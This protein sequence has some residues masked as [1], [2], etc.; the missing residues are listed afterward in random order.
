MIDT[1]ALRWHL[2]RFTDLSA[3]HLYDLLRL[4]SEVFVV[5]QDC[6]YLDIDGKDRHPEAWHLLGLAP[7][8]SLVAYLRIMPPGLGHGSGDFAEPS[9]GRVVTAPGW[10]G[11]GLG[12]PLLR[13]GIA[14]AER[15]W[16][17]TPI[18]LGAQSHLQ[19]YYARHGFVPA[20]EPYVED[21]IP[22]VE[23]LRPGHHETHPHKEPS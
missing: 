13:E 1:P 20:S 22:H 8:G 6:A 17:G 12:D 3:D 5:E 2:A 15:E 16:P 18:R 19:H 11:K 9:I 21:G 7:D 14:L 4:R 23:M 10:R